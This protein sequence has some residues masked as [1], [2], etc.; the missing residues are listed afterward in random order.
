MTIEYMEE[1]YV[2]FKHFEREQII[3]IQEYQYKKLAYKLSWTIAGRESPNNSAKNH[4]R[5]GT[6]IST[7]K[8]YKRPIST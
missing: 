2:W 7:Q 1:T 8:K 4:Q 6:D 3:H 5:I